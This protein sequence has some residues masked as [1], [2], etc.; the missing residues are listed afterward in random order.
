MTETDYYIGLTLPHG[1][2]KF[3][4]RVI[5]REHGMDIATIAL[6]HDALTAFDALEVGLTTCYTRRGHNQIVHAKPDLSPTG[7]IDRGMDGEQA[8]GGALAQV[9]HMIVGKMISKF[10]EEGRD[11]AI[12]AVKNPGTIWKKVGRKPTHQIVA[13]I[14]FKTANNH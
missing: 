12:E 4:D 13:I 2:Y 6:Q 10:F 3:I 7:I 9:S 1:D 11:V 8:F 14:P 5:R